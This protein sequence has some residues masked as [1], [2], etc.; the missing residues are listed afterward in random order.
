MGAEILALRGVGTRVRADT[1][2][3][4]YAALAQVLH[5][6]R[7]NSALLEAQTQ[8][9]FEQLSKKEEELRLARSAQR[10]SDARVGT[11]AAEAQCQ[12]DLFVTTQVLSS[13]VSQSCHFVLRVWWAL[14]SSP[15]IELS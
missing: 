13:L 2:A 6:E 7:E 14:F 12:R 5:R 8:A 11:L 1:S 3:L 4:D 9:S 10:S 15:V